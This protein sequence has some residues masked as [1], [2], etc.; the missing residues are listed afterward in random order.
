[1]LIRR[2]IR[3]SATASSEARAQGTAALARSFATGELDPAEHLEGETALIALLDDPVPLVRLAMAVELCSMPDLPRALLA[4]LVADRSDIAAIMLEFSPVPSVAELVDAVALGDAAVQAAVARRHGIDV[5]LAAALAEVAGADA[6]LALCRN[7]SAPLPSCAVDRMLERFGA[8]AELRAALADRADLRP[9]QRHAL[10]RHTAQQLAGFASRCGW[11]PPERAARIAAD[12][13]EQ[14]C[15]TVVAALPVDTR[16]A[17]DRA[18]FVAQLRHRGALTP[19]LMLRALLCGSFGFLEAAFSELSGMPVPRVAGLL[20]ASRGLGFRSLFDRAG[21][22]A[23]LRAVFVA[24]LEAAPPHEGTGALQRRR[25]SGALSACERAG[26]EDGLASVAALLR[27]FDAEGARTE[28]RAFARDVRS[29]QVLLLLPRPSGAD[30]C[31]PLPS[32]A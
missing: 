27:R 30:R 15:V 23:P 5:R 22:P 18:T 16:G 25:V 4:G 24:A 3:W 8:H 29:E 10:A 7:G 14:A 28:A 9:A 21:L 2:F 26:S 17:A 11:L 1:M 32:A 13:T 20:R 31:L 6:C 19:A 12:A